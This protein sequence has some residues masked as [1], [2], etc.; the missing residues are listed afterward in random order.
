MGYI[1][2]VPVDPIELEDEKK[3]EFWYKKKNMKVFSFI[4]PKNPIKTIDLLSYSPINF[5]ECFKRFDSYGRNKNP[6]GFTKRFINSQK[7]IKKREG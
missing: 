4:H 2:K 6:R 5:E 1:P 7:D 3:R